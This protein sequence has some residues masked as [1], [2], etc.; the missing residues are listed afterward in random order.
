MESDNPI[1]I[2]SFF[3]IIIL[4]ISYLSVRGS[5]NPNPMVSFIL[6]IIITIAYFAIKYTLL[7]QDDESNY[8]LIA[9]CIYIGINIISQLTSNISLSNQICGS[10]QW[11]NTFLITIIPWIVIFGL[12]I[13]LL[14]IFPGWL[15]PFSNTLGYGITKLFGI[16]DLLGNILVNE[17]KTNSNTLNK[18]LQEIYSN[19]SL[20]IN[21]VSI[22]NFNEF[23]S[24]LKNANM[25]KSGVTN[26]QKQEF[27]NLVFLK[28]II[29]EFTW[30]ILVGLLTISATY[31][32]IINLTCNQSVAS[33]KAR[34]DEHDEEV[35]LHRKAE[36]SAPD[37]RVYT[38]FE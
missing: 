24:S 26:E 28:T 37:K 22:E 4:I 3:L 15:I 35:Q 1:P 17:S 10:S 13:I 27:K 6:F 38:S 5:N 9:Q 2:F 31:N 18:A 32:Y 16:D 14:L 29:S 33:M 30:Y 12:L 7:T 34:H 20:L 25:L 23:W 19:K 11:F 8:L 36:E 21:Q